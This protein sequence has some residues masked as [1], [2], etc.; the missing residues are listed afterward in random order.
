MPTNQTTTGRGYP[1][2]HPT[3]LLADDVL[4]L[5][6]ALQAIDDDI[7]ARPTSTTVQ[8]LV[9]QAAADLV[10]GSP[11]A[12]N[13]LNELA[14]ALGD[15]ANFATTVTN[16]L[17]ARLQ[18]SGGTMT[19]PITLSGDPGQALHA[20]TK[21]YVDAAA[22]TNATAIN[23]KA[24]KSG[25]SFTGLLQALAGF[26]VTGLA[27]VDPIA[28]RVNVTASA[29]TAPQA[30]PLSGKAV[31]FHTANATTNFTAN[32]TGLSAL[33]VG[34]SATFAVLVTNGATPYYITSI[35][36]D[37]TTSGVSTRWQGGTAPSSGNASSIDSYSITIIKTGAGTYTVLAAQTK[38]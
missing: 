31:V 8:N 23:G 2:P 21:Q 28:E 26:A 7:T 24:S 32:F 18:L 11:A 13:T 12:L 19:G 22:S 17:A 10:D 27:T 33:A 1:L 30:Y 37:G 6:D 20:A 35:Q 34:D 38:F 36:V 16:A 14:A 29:P 5:R 25:D 15:D 3:N 9:A 4:R